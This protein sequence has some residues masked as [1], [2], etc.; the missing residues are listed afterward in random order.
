MTFFTQFNSPLRLN[1][2]LDYSS[3]VKSHLN[4]YYEEVDKAFDEYIAKGFLLPENKKQYL[5]ELKIT[6]EQIVTIL[7]CYV[8][9]ERF[10]AVDNFRK[11]IKSYKRII[12]NQFFHNKLSIGTVFFRIRTDRGAIISRNSG[13]I[14][15]EH[16]LFHIP[17]SQRYKVNNLRFNAQGIPCLYCSTDLLTAWRETKEIGKTGLG[18]GDKS[19]NIAAYR[20]SSPIAYI[21]F[22]LQNFDKFTTGLNSYN[23][24]KLLL[25]I[26]IYPLVM[27]LHTKI[28]FGN[29]TVAFY[30]DYVI[31]TLIMD[32]FLSKDGKIPSRAH[33]VI[34]IKYSSVEN[35]VPITGYNYV[36]PTTHK[37]KEEYCTLLS[38]VLLSNG[39]Y[40]YLYEDQILKMYSI[41]GPN[42]IQLLEK[43][44]R[45]ALKGGR[46]S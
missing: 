18:N 30:H 1:K 34:C 19:L 22:S 24:S 11:L 9:G 45:S 26:K 15:P 12:S 5:K 39:S 37:G 25:Y 43:Q 13:S 7:T 46:S 29:E 17:F 38:N 4:Y 10:Q 40:Y 14:P 33:T 44:I 27:A 8:K 16:I 20:N 31:P 21:D 23:F 28:D 41:I 42:E 36:F 2:A 6:S 32:W 35:N 3:E